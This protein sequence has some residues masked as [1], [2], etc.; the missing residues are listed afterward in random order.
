MQTLEGV[1]ILDFTTLLLEPLA[2]LMLADMGAEMLK[3]TSPARRN[4]V[5]DAQ[6][7]IA[8]TGIS[9]NQAWRLI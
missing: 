8:D 1:K 4:L 7:F 3:I 9:P 5:L 2:T 6:L